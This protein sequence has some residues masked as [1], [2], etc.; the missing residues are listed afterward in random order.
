[1]SE[2]WEKNRLLNIKTDSV[3]KSEKRK[4]TV[5]GDGYRDGALRDG[6]NAIILRCDGDRKVLVVFSVVVT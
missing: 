1:M 3:E 2:Q 6:G 4:L 5:V